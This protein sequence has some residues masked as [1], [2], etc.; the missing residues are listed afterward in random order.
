MAAKYNPNKCDDVAKVIKKF[1]PMVADDENG[2]HWT[3]TLDENT[4]RFTL[5]KNDEMFYSHVH[6]VA[7]IAK[8][9]T[10]GVTLKGV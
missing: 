6:S 2:N 7:C 8:A 9:N 1:Q 5:R 10:L 3:L 4:T